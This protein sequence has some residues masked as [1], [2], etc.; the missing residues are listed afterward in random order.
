M[1]TAEVQLTAASP[2]AG[3]APGPYVMLAVHDTGVGMDSATR[4]R[5]FEPFFTTK[6]A[7]KGTGLGLSTVYGIVQQSGGALEVESAPGAG[8]LFRVL[9]PRAPAAAP[10][11][12]EE[13]T[14]APQPSPGGSECV[15][16][17][18]DELAVRRAACRIL[19]RQ[20]YRVLE[21]RHGADA[22]QV[23]AGAEGAQVQLVLT[24][25]VMPEMGGAELVRR[26]RAQGHPARVLFMS[27]YSEEAV[28]THGVLVEG[29][30]LLEKPFELDVLLRRVREVLDASPPP[31][32]RGQG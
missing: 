29:V 18:E 22:L 28:A 2:R 10:G 11:P 16:V 8:T 32:G 1:E 4:A 3:L 30:G 20:G 25:V 15:L 14:A 7:G 12:G 9:L 13:E 6:E 31:S 26:L 21:A 24:D 19:E 27:G 5:I 17:V 23:L